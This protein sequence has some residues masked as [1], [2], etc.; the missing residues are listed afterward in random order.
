[1]SDGCVIGASELSETVALYRSVAVAV[2]LVGLQ[3]RHPALAIAFKL[4]HG[5]RPEQQTS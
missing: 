2:G 4:N 5:P 3:L 1:M